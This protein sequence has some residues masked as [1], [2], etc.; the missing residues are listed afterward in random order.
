MRKYTLLYLALIIETI[1]CFLVLARMLNDGKP[2]KIIT[3]GLGFLTILTMTIYLLIQL[4]VKNQ[5]VESREVRKS[6]N[7]KVCKKDMPSSI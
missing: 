3:A 2:W 5:E 1:A 6:E 4:R 7:P